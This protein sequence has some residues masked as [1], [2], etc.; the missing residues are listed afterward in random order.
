MASYEQYTKDGVKLWRVRVYLGLD[1]YTHKK[2]STKRAGFNT[3]KE[4][5]LAVSKLKLDF[6]N[7]GNIDRPKMMVFN[8]LYQQWL[9]GYKNTV[10]ESTF[11]RVNGMFR[12]H[13]L[14]KGAFDGVIVD[15]ITL[16]YVQKL[17]NKWSKQL[18][19]YKKLVQYVSKVFDYAVKLE[20]VSKNHFKDVTYPKKMETSKNVIK[21]EDNWL[22]KIQLKKFFIT[23]NTIY[24]GN[25]NYMVLV[26]FRLLA[27]TGARKG[28]L[29]ALNWKD[30]NLDTG[31]LSIKKTIS[32]GENNNMYVTDSA[33][34]KAGMRDL[35]LDNETLS[36]L[37]HWRMLQ[38]SVMFEHG[39]NINTKKDQFLFSR[40][41]DNNNINVMTPNHWLERVLRNSD[42]PKIT[43]HGFRH[44]YATLAIESGMNVKQLQK[45]LGH[46]DIK[47]TLDIYTAVTEHGKQ[48]TTELFSSY[49]GF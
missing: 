2:V 28:E 27:F 17:V 4:A 18:V 44:T 38:R 45:Q 7:R 19:H 39:F 8:E 37:K 14:I 35:I 32:R 46:A 25:D 26:F 21:S 11:N 24:S 5:Q 31:V 12:N 15:K 22:D 9:I 16:P 23:L 49:V 6:D 41:N 40:F 20:I 30:I 42:L 33:K 3:K 1:P 48:E 29:I 10:S 43:V 13:V 36:M 34:T 47:T